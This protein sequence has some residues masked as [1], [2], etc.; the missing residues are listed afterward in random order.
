[1]SPLSAAQQRSVAALVGARRLERVPVDERMRR[2][3]NRQRY[4]AQPITIAAATVASEAATLLVRA[5]HARVH[6]GP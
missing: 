2:D 3:R 1:V 5:G 6:P 4:N